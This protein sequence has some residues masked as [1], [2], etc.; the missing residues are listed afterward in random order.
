LVAIRRVEK[1]GMQPWQPDESY[2]YPPYG[3]PIPGYGWQYVLPTPRFAYASFWRRFFALI[4]DSILVGIAAVSLIA[5]LWGVTG[6]ELFD[7]D[8]TGDSFSL[9]ASNWPIAIL[10]T[11]YF[12][13]LNGRGA[14]IG[15]KALGIIVTGREGKAPGLKRGILRGIIPAVGSALDPI[16]SLVT[17]IANEIGGWDAALT[18]GLVGLSILLGY[19]LFQIVDGLSML[20]DDHRQTIHDK[21]GGTY[22]IRD[23][24]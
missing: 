17:D 13:Y 23:H 12:V 1:H 10:T 15:K 9:S 11:A 3:A 14:T 5:I 24:G 6:I 16:L 20:G 18:T 8:T 19:S 4:L 2:R 22:V 21:M 7:I